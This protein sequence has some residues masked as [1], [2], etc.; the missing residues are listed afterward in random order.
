MH[1]VAKAHHRIFKEHV[2]GD[3][4]DALVD[5]GFP[6]ITQGAC[7]TTPTSEL[8]DCICLPYGAPGW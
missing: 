5:T 7:W 3:C 2:G 8:R 1:E 6:A 4:R